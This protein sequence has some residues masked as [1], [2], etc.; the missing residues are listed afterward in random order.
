M[1]KVPTGIVAEWNPSYSECVGKK[2]R[3]SMY[4]VQEGTAC[5]SND[6]EVCQKDEAQLH[7]SV[8]AVIHF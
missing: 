1:A 4:L 3:S 7:I 2:G 5:V 8:N 6:K